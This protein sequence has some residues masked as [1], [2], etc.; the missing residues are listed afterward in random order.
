[1]IDKSDM[2]SSKKDEDERYKKKT[3]NPIKIANESIIV[4]ADGKKAE[5]VSKEEYDKLKKEHD[6]TKKQLKTLN[7]KVQ[8]LEKFLTK[9]TK[10][11]SNEISSLSEKVN[12]RF[13]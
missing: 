10:S 6:D 11:V 9:F 12:A 5:V 4:E 7:V 1:M 3:S 13:N 8:Q 2:Y